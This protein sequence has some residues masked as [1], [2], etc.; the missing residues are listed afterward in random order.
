MRSERIA[1]LGRKLGTIN[2]N[3]AQTYVSGYITKFKV[4]LLTP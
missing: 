4:H 3:F 1:S 2:G